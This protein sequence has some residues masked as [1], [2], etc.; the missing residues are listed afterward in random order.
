MALALALGAC[1]D[2]DDAPAVDGSVSDAPLPGEVTYQAWGIISGYNRV[3]ITRADPVRD[4]CAGLVLIEPGEPAFDIT[5]PE[6]W[7]VEHSFAYL[8]AAGC[9]ESRFVPDT[10]SLAS[11]GSG[12]VTLGQALSTV[13]VDVVLSFASP[14]VPD[15][16]ELVA[17]ELGVS[18]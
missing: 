8:G 6:G 13:S 12:T 7:G 9:H 2:G 18:F 14:W 10:A 1:T 17:S 15:R 11:A 3:L 4:V 5:L 16:I